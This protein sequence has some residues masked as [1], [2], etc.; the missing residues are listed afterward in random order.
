MSVGSGRAWPMAGRRWLAV[1]VVEA[2]GAG[3]D[4]AG[5]PAL[6]SEEP[7]Y[8]GGPA[9][10]GGRGRRRGGAVA[11]SGE[12]EVRAREIFGRESNRES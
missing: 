5:T 10:R 7:G 9:M 4:A 11:L 3:E 6:A 8:R 12:G 2:K 1:G